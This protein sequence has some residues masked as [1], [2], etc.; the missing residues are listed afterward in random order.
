MN[1][2]KCINGHFY[3]GDIY[4]YCPHCGP[5]DQGKQFAH[6]KRDKMIFNISLLDYV[7]GNETY[8]C[9]VHHPLRTAM[10]TPFSHP[11]DKI[12]VIYN[13]L[14]NSRVKTEKYKLILKMNSNVK[15][16]QANINIQAKWD[17]I[18]KYQLPI[19]DAMESWDFIFSKSEMA[20]D[21]HF[22]EYEHLYDNVY[23]RKSDMLERKT[24]GNFISF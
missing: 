24:N 2:K 8:C 21:S 9:I 6:K 16:N 1:V 20:I 14:F 17:Q 15:L 10:I 18:A 22:C 3:D 5:K 13:G 19:C 4:D 23:V 11:V 12:Y 7:R